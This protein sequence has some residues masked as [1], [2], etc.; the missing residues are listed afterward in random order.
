MHLNHKV[1]I[2]KSIAGYQKAWARLSFSHIG[3]LYYAKNLKLDHPIT[4]AYIDSGGE[5]AADSRFALGP[6]TGKEWNTL[7]RAGL[8]CNRGLRKV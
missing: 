4:P 7:G 8:D 3:S 1:E 2:M 5:I 6:I